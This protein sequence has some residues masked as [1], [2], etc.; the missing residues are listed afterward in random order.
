MP[1]S[2]PIRVLYM[3]DDPGLKRLVM[4]GYTLEEDLREL[5]GEGILGVVNKPFTVDGLA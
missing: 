4:T 5:R 3:E 2:K 1:G